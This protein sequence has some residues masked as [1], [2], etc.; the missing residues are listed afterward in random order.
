MMKYGYHEARKMSVD[1]LRGL[2]IRKNW[3]TAGNNKNYSEMLNKADD[4]ENIT[5]DD[6]IEIATAIQSNSHMDPE[7]STEEN[8]ESICFELFSIC[9]TFIEK[10]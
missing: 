10:N 1:S 4:T 9:N 6:I 3:F 2:C 5:T 7:Y 8:F